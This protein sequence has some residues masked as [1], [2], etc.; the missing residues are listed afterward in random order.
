MSYPFYLFNIE[1][2]NDRHFNGWISI[3]EKILI[4]KDKLTCVSKAII[5]NN[6]FRVFS[7]SGLYIN[8]AVKLI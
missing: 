3:D 8:T 1:K 4:I 2:L 7:S 5:K 6:A